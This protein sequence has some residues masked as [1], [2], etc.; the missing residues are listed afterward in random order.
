MSG[1]ASGIPWLSNASYVSLPSHGGGLHL[2]PFVGNRERLDARHRV[3]VGCLGGGGGGDVRRVHPKVARDH[4]RQRVAAASLAINSDLHTVRLAG[5]IERKRDVRWGDRDVGAHHGILQRRGDRVLDGW[6]GR[7][8]IVPVVVHQ[9]IHPGERTGIGGVLCLVAGGH[10]HADVDGQHARADEG[11]HAE[12]DEH[13]AHARLIS[14][15]LCDS[16]H[17]AL[18]SPCQRR[19]RFESAHWSTRYSF[20]ISA[21]DC[22]VSGAP[23]VEPLRISRATGLRTMK[24]NG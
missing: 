2:A 7:A 16:L 19:L 9:S 15:E 13:E 18:R 14:S 8:A 17:G 23:R 1:F 6:T 5:R 21:D 11:H 4:G 12:A 24:A 3:G 20:R 22:I 10:H